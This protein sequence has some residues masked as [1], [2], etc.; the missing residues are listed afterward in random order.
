MWV[1]SLS[2]GGTATFA[3]LSAGTAELNPRQTYLLI[4]T[5]NF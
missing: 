3:E 4:Q 2:H 5:L 1:G